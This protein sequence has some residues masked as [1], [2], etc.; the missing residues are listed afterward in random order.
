LS[1]AVDQFN[2]MLRTGKKEIN[3]QRKKNATS[4]GESDDDDDD[5]VAKGDS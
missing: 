3:E 4:C 2:F 1:E 5:E